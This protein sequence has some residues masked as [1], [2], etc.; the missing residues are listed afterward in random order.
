MVVAVAFLTGSVDTEVFLLFL[1]ISVLYGLILSFGAI[2]IEDAS[3]GR[4]PGWDQLGRI[5]LFATLENAGYRQLGHLWRLE[6][7][8]SSCD[9]ASGER[10]SARGFHSPG[11]RLCSVTRW[12]LR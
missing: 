9:A 11:P 4:H 10:W 2:A 6:G 1:A 8:G 7:F 3:F 5:M 12:G